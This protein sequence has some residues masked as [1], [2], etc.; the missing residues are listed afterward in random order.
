MILFSVEYLELY[1]SNFRL[2]H[3]LNG[4]ISLIFTHN[5]NSGRENE[6]GPLAI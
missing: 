5:L 4:Y 2:C 3:G 6:K 1:T